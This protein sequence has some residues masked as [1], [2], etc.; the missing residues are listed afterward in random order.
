MNDYRRFFFREICREKTQKTQIRLTRSCEGREEKE[1]TPD[2]E[3]TAEAPIPR[4]YIRLS[5]LFFAA[6]R[7]IQ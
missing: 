2:R 7:E 1:S 4:S 6:S 3:N 5:C